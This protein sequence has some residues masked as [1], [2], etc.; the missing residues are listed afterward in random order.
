MFFLGLY[1][2]GREGNAKFYQITFLSLVIGLIFERQAINWLK[3][4]YGCTH[5]RLQKFIELDQRR[6]SL[7]HNWDIVPAPYD[8]ERYRQH[9]FYNEFDLYKKK[10][11]HNLAVSTK[12]KVIDEHGNK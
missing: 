2:D 12:V 9:Y 1:K 11:T 5:Y 7:R 4:R 10:F 6:E 8:V 3:D